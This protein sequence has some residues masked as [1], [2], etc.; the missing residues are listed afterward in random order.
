MDLVFYFNFFTLTLSLYNIKCTINI[1][2]NKCLKGNY[3]DALMNSSRSTFFS[4]I[5][6]RKSFSNFSPTFS[7]IFNS[8]QLAY[9]LMRIIEM[10]AYLQ[11]SIDSVLLRFRKQ[12]TESVLV[13]TCSFLKIQNLAQ[14]LLMLKCSVL[15]FRG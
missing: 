15:T 7:S 6:E 3:L 10:H 13:R 9:V 12:K 4:K 1:H 14:Y 8:E 11:I 5:Y 2:V